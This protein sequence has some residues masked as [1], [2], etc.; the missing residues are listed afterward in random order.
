M[1]VADIDAGLVQNAAKLCGG[2]GVALD[3]TAPLP[4]PPAS[5]DA[6]VVVDFVHENLLQ[7]I[8][9]VLRSGGWLMYESYS[10]RG[11]NWRQLLRPGATIALLRPAFEVIKCATRPAGPTGCEAEVVQLLARR[12]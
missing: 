6:A 11:R 3:A 12:H 8:G 7:N 4:F 2:L 1:A 5:F 10:A 9:D